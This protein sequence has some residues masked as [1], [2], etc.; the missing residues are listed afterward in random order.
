MRRALVFLPSLVI[1]LAGLVWLLVR[2]GS[3]TPRLAFGWQLALG[4]AVGAALLGLA[5]LLE[6]RLASF[7]YASQITEHALRSLALPLW[8]WPLLA[9]LTAGGE[10]LFFRG[11]LLPLVGVLLQA[12]LFG[13]FHPVPPRAWAYP[14]FVAVAGLLFGWLTLASG[15]L[16]PAVTAHLAVNLHGFW[17]AGRGQPAGRDR[18]G[19]DNGSDDGSDGG[20]DGGSGSA[21]DDDV[22]LGD[23]ESAPP[24]ADL[25]TDA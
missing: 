18:R 5:Q 4:L 24:A 17:E 23:G 2:G 11:A 9:L 3:Y 6:R 12:L 22:R 1:G 21:G 19:D 8:A 15:S 10:E 14:L 16:L 25:R 20:S 7:R 13:L